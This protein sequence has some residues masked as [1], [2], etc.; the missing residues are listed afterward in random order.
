MDAEIA[1]KMDKGECEELS[2]KSSMVVVRTHKRYRPSA[3]DECC[4]QIVGSESEG[5]V[6]GGGGINS[7]LG[8]PR[9]KLEL[10]MSKKIVVDKKSMT[11]K[12]LFDTGLID[13][14]SV[15]YMCSIKKVRFD[16]RE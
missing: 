6:N 14:V 13:G 11:V 5:V 2:N 4:D 16:L 1:V 3:K 8:T 15:V 12:E 9:N 7:A 10:K